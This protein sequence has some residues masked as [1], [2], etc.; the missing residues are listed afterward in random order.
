MFRRDLGDITSF[1]VNF[2][3]VLHFHDMLRGDCNREWQAGKEIWSSVKKECRFSNQRLGLDLGHPSWVMEWVRGIDENDIGN[4][5]VPV[6]YIF[7]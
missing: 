6:W 4:L 1:V 5:P 3:T 2:Q 7:T